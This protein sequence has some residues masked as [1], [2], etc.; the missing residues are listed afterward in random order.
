MEKQKLIT[1]PYSQT[2]MDLGG[3]RGKQ[4]LSAHPRQAGGGLQRRGPWLEPHIF[5]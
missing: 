4:Q 1:R 5:I 2:E 3:E